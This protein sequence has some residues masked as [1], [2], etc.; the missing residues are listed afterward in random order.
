MAVASEIGIRSKDLTAKAGKDY[1]AITE[2]NQKLTFADKEYEK[3]VVIEIID[4][5]QWTEDR[6]FEIE[7][8]DL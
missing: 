1:Q 3:I 7:L 6:E 8:F 2:A 5:E 4:D